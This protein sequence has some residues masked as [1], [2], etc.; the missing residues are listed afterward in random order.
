M[1]MKKEEVVAQKTI[2]PSSQP[3]WRVSDGKEIQA[4][5]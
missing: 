2:V 4:L 3:N 5:P 1:E